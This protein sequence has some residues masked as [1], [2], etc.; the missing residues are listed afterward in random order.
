MT[1]RTA[2]LAVMLSSLGPATLTWAVGGNVA[3]TVTDASGGALAD[4]TITLT[5]SDPASNLQPVQATTRSDGTVDVPAEEGA[6]RLTV[7]KDNVTTAQDVTVR[8]GATTRT[9]VTL[10]A[11]WMSQLPGGLGGLAAGPVYRGSWTDLRLGDETERIAIRTGTST[12]MGVLDRPSRNNDF[13][14]E[15]NAGGVEIAAGLPALKL[16]ISASIFTAI[17]LT[18]GAAGAR[19]DVDNPDVPE[20]SFRLSGTGALLGAGLEAVIVPG[21]RFPLFFGLGYQFNWASADVDRSPCA[22]PAPFTGLE[23]C[24][25]DGDLTYR[26]HAVWGRVGYSVLEGRMSPY[27]GL[28]GVWTNLDVESRIMR[29]FAGGA[30]TVTNDIDMELKRSQVQGL[31]GLDAWICGLLFGRVEVAFDGDGVDVLAKLRF[32]FNVG[33]R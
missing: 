25:D 3:V 9:R 33:G 16:P 19:I 17:N 11:G 32:G 4:A 12:S 7:T 31:V 2:V 18:A 13:D 20:A 1:K 28:R 14:L 24:A 26:S 8:G 21:A 27:V 29:S 6:Y 23:S 5:P 10:A 22:P 15:L 30:V